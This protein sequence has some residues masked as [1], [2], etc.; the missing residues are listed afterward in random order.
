MAYTRLKE[1]KNIKNSVKKT[2]LPN[3]R[4]IATQDGAPPDVE[5]VSDDGPEKGKILEV[6][7]QTFETTTREIIRELA[8]TRSG[9]TSVTYLP[10]TGILVSTDRR[11]HLHHPR[12]GGAYTNL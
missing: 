9:H 11:N 4:W 7:R 10:H 12:S 6:L 1:E 3:H 8:S 2:Y 5:L